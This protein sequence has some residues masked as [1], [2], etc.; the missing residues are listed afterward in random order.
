M[1]KSNFKPVTALNKYI[2][3][4]NLKKVFEQV[5][6]QNKMH[7]QGEKSTN[8]TM[9]IIEIER[10]KFS[11]VLYA[12]CEFGE[13]HGWPKEWYEN[14]TFKIPCAYSIPKKSYNTAYKALCNL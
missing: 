2:P 3:Q 7:E 4:K 6:N 11:I 13:V 5:I 1:F 10:N 14:R 8:W 9:D 12:I